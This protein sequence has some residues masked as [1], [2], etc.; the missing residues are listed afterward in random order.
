MQPTY[1]PWLG[2]FDLIDQS[3]IFVFL[4]SVQFEK[5]SWQQR[6]RIRTAK[7]LDWLTVPVKVTGRSRQLIRE[8][9]IVLSSLFPRKHV[10]SIEYN[11]S[12]APYFNLYWDKLHEIL[13]SGEN[14]LCQLNMRLVR[15]LAE[16]FGISTHFEISSE[17]GVNG[18]RTNLLVDICRRLGAKTYLSPVGS[19]A[20]LRDEHKVFEEN[21]IQIVFQNFNHPTYHQ[22]H[23]PFVPYVS[24]IDLL[25]NQGDRAL[26]IIRSGRGAVI[27]LE[28]MLDQPQMS[29]LYIDQGQIGRDS[30]V[31]G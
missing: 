24:A 6:N 14:L 19:A 22:V 5:Q 23:E 31:K 3:T 27:T 13:T 18:K 21:K 12:K 15:W 28:K 17:L 16:E 4:D 30:P 9:E 25:F 26:E 7:G 2:Y 1:L 29:A 8:T 20:Y 11:Y 10:R